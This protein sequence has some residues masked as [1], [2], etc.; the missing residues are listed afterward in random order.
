MAAVVNAYGAK[1]TMNGGKIANNVVIPRQNV[2]G[3][4]RGG[5]VYNDATFTFNGGEI[6]GN[7][8][9][10]DSDV[11]Y[12]TYTLYCAG[13]YNSK[14]LTINGGTIAGN[15]YAFN[16][17]DGNKLSFDGVGVSNNGGM[18]TITNGII[19]D[20]YCKNGDANGVGLAVTSNS[21]NDAT[22]IM[23]GG[24]I[25]GNKSGT[26][27]G[28]GLY[29]GGS[30][31]HTVTADISGGKI[32]DN[33]GANGVSFNSLVT[34]N[35]S[36]SPVIT[37][38]KTTAGAES[39]VYLPNNAALTLKG[40]LTAGA[41]IKVTGEGTVVAKG[42]DEYT[43]T[44]ADAAYFA[45]NGNKLVQKD[46]TENQLVL[47]EKE[48]GKTYFTVTLNLPNHVKANKGQSTVVENGSKYEVSFTTET[49]YKI[50]SVTV[51]GKEKKLENGKLT[52]DS[53]SA[54]T[55]ITVTEE[56]KAAPTLTL[57]SNR[58]IFRINRGPVTF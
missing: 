53:I 3:N 22:L 9:K 8:C 13:L 4:A 31:E 49:G 28:A 50:S 36:G 54:D 27:A 40:A 41:T 19:K 43:V 47:T 10:Q 23:T 2:Y 12:T 1:A 17:G 39:D 45:H 52:L 30:G 51:N 18:L 32:V 46:A 48:E 44:D 34:L 55:T 35:L 14:V 57:S 56:K 38:N 58:G 37:G 7:R 20:N 29:L 6:V 25:R 33:T 15:Y 24:T 42:T 5:G 21:Q 16:E 26:K 11:S